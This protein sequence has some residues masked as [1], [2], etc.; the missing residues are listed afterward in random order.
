VTSIE[1][2]RR[3]QSAFERINTMQTRRWTIPRGWTPRSGSQ[4]WRNATGCSAGIARTGMVD[5]EGA[6]AVYVQGPLPRKLAID[7]HSAGRKSLL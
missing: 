7:Q 5:N 4:F 6:D 2:L 1:H 3:I